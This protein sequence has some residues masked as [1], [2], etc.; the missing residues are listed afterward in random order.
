M[1]SNQTATRLPPLNGDLL[2]G[3][4]ELFTFRE[5]SR[6]T[7]DSESFWRAQAASGAVETVRFGKSTRIPR[8]EMVRVLREGIKPIRRAPKSAA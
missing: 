8:R 3:P 2:D 4:Q 6:I 1:E 7:G 5:A